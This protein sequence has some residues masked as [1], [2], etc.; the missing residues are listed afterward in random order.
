MT[1]GSKAGILSTF[2]WVENIGFFVQNPV[3][4]IIIDKILDQSF[5]EDCSGV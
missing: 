4:E 5:L 3:M 1:G 2:P